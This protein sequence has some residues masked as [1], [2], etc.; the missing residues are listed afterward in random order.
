MCEFV[1]WFLRYAHLG[2]SALFFSVRCLL[3]LSNS[4]FSYTGPTDISSYHVF[5]SLQA[6]VLLCG[7]FFAV[8]LCGVFLVFFLFWFGLGWVFCFFVES[9]WVSVLNVAWFWESSCIIM[10]HLYA[11]SMQLLPSPPTI[12][13]LLMYFM[14]GGG[15]GTWNSKGEGSQ[16]AQLSTHTDSLWSKGLGILW[17]LQLFHRY[18]ILKY[19]LL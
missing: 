18:L 16:G 5:V 11:F 9:V 7:F 4:R 19:F 12:L 14:A 13:F 8:L 1:S 2:L 6:A 3:F 17:S 15:N 10:I